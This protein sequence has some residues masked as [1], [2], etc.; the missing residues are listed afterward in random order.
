[1]FDREPV[2]WY[3]VAIAAVYTLTEYGVELTDG[4]QTAT[5]GL[6]AAVLGLVTRS[7]VTPW[8]PGDPIGGVS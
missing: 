8:K 5:L 4:Q 3:T 7:K 2:A 6:V 1:M